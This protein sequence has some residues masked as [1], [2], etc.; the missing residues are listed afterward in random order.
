LRALA[1]L[2]MP[3]HNRTLILSRDPAQGQSL[4]TS[5]GGL[6]EERRGADKEGAEEEGLRGGG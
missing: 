2:A 6:K 1:D 5:G 4:L 3:A